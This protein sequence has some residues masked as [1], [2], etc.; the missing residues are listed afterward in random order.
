[1]SYQTRSIVIVAI[2][3][4][5]A[6]SPASAQA[7]ADLNGDGIVTRA[8]ATEAR[9]RMFDRIDRNRDGVISM[10]EI[11]RVRARIQ[12]MAG[13][14]DAAVTLAPDRLDADRNGE[15][16]RVE[17][18]ELPFFDVADRNADGVLDEAEMAAARTLVQGK[19]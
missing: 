18:L 2:I 4:T 14:A 6:A 19:Q 13:M 7:R 17:F 9:G 10:T 5:V 8:E 1:M 12:A 3:A 16:S 11:E 15:I